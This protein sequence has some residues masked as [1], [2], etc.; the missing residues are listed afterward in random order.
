MSNALVLGGTG[1][2]SAS[3]TRQLVERGVHVTVFHRGV[4]AQPLPPEV[5]VLRGDRNEREAF[6]GA[7][8]SSRFDVV[9]DMIGYSPEQAAD[10][11]RAFAGRCHQLVYCSSAV[12]YGPQLPAAVLVD[13]RCPL[14]P[15]NPYGEAK[16]ACER[17]L[18]D[19]AGAGAFHLTILRP[20]H[21]YGPGVHLD[22][23]LESE[24]LAWD[25]VARGLPVLVAGDGLGLWQ[26]THRDDC[27]RYFAAAALCERA[28]GEAYN[29][30]DPR[31]I[32][33]RGYYAE[34]ARALHT[35]AR[36]V[37]VPA[38]WLLA[39]APGRF[40]F[41]AGISGE[42]CAFSAEKALR[43]LGLSPDWVSLE[44]GAEETFADVRRRGAWPDSRPDTEYQALV[45]RAVAFGC[46]I[47]EL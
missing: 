39:Q 1:L 3:L 29:A 21:T 30:V 46:P 8:A 25:R 7:F 9:Y 15:T 40:G 27:A 34:V 44:A 10:T 37:F 26:A 33:W 36:V 11:V 28:Y 31:V 42:H 41:L 4:T 22:D 17:V 43:G 20:A 32:S 5:S 2:I 23:Q 6:V 18:Q 16:V 45:D 13:E 35:R 19:A 14:R 24:G 12:V 47:E 38:G